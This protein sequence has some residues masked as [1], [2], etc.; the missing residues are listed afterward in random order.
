M[1]YN[2]NNNSIIPIY[3]TEKMWRVWLHDV[4]NYDN[5]PADLQDYSNFPTSAFD[6]DAMCTQLCYSSK[7]ASIDRPNL[8]VEPYVPLKL[9][10][11]PTAP[12]DPYVPSRVS[13]P[14]IDLLS[15][16][17]WP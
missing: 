9:L 15:V 2:N 1:I 11:V 7:L 3:K 14:L 8:P 17:Y 5:V 16:I 4:A 12:I 13:N 6:T 10:P